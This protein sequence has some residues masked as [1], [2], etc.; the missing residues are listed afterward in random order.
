MSA[1]ELRELLNTACHVA[2]GRDWP[3]TP[4]PWCCEGAAVYGPSRCTCWAPVYDQEQ[5]PLQPEVPPSV[6]TEMCADCAYRPGSPERQGDPDYRGDRQNLDELV[7]AGRPF[8]CHQGMRKPVRYRH[9]CGMEIEGHPAEYDPPQQGA[10]PFKADGTP[11]DLC[12]GWASRRI[13]LLRAGS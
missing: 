3:D 5:Q 11:G 6:R 4:E 8:W 9:P 13:A 7:A 12:N 10:V 2:M 1:Q